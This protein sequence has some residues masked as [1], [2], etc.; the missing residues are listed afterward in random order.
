MADDK[1]KKR[2]ARKALDNP[3]YV[4]RRDE[5]VREKNKKKE[6]RAAKKEQRKRIKEQIKAADAYQ[7]PV[8]E[9]KDSPVEPISPSQ[10]TKVLNIIQKREGGFDEDQYESRE[11]FK[12]KRPSISHIAQ[13]APSGAEVKNKINENAVKKGNTLTEINEAKDN[14]NKVEND[15]N[16]VEKNISDQEAADNVQNQIISN[17]IKDQDDADVKTRQEQAGYVPY[18]GDGSFVGQLAR[19][20]DGGYDLT[21]EDL[22]KMGEEH[23]KQFELQKA[24]APSAAVEKLGMEYYYPP[25]QDY[26]T[27]SFTGRYIGSRQLVAA[28]GALFP[29]GLVDAR[30]RAQQEKA[31]AKAD[32]EANFWKLEGTAEQYDEMYKDIGMDVLL[33]Y[34]NLSAG[35]IEGLLAGK[36]K[37]SQEFL[38][39][40]Y[41]YK[42]RG[43]MI[44]DANTMVDDLI[45]NIGTEG[46]YYPPEIIKTANDFRAGTSNL[47]D[48]FDGKAMGD[49]QVKA[50]INS[51]RSFENF[52]EIA[53]KELALMLKDNANELPLNMNNPDWGKMDAE[54]NSIFAQNMQQAINQVKNKGVGYD[55][56]T[57]AMME[58]YDVQEVERIVRT[59]YENHNLWEGEDLE[60]QIESGVK[61]FMAVLPDKIDIDH[62]LQANKS[63]EAYRARLAAE[64]LELKKYRVAKD[65]Y[66][67]WEGANGDQEAI[68]D[69]LH[70]I[71]NDPK[72]KITSD[73][74]DKEK[75]KIRNAKR[76]AKKNL[77]K[78]ANM[79]PTNLGG[80]IVYKIP[81]EGTHIG[82]APA[83]DMLVISP[84]DG[85]LYRAKSLYNIYSKRKDKQGGKLSKEDQATFNELKEVVV[86]Q[87]GQNIQ[88]H[89]SGR[90][91]GSS[92]YDRSQSA[93]IPN[94]RYEGDYGLDDMKNTGYL[95]GRVGIPIDMKDAKE[96][97]MYKDG[98]KPSKLNYVQMFDSE[99]ENTTRTALLFEGT[100]ENRDS[101][102]SIDFSDPMY[103]VGGE[104]Q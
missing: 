83:D 71:D 51:L 66:N 82:S 86:N 42:A 18:P 32:L 21:D 38:R 58:F 52:H 84:K 23:R 55:E 3:D 25:Q 50:M 98:Y 26:V 56:F 40:M 36:T 62:T 53:N 14:A 95:S 28:T 61:Y 2:K 88:H 8:E 13:N 33:K 20:G 103:Q 24:L 74:S 102:Y 73:M 63:I 64:E 70:K 97:E 60:K 46:T 85:K 72:Y 27:S 92:V 54:G 77:Y 69:E 35:D 45:S 94:G 91:E 30:K 19:D 29:E 80:S 65:Y 87:K 16:N 17:E 100:R 89:I 68:N 79:N 48:Y 6:E 43:K 5:K 22:A 101:K 57:S 78:N 10:K 39:A 96:V 9:G 47:Y 12:A 37:L 59:I 81:T 11:D 49:D 7:R 90:F 34:Y 15:I 1:R 76:M 93:Y 31:Q 44:V 99:N 75:K 67:L 104:D 4:A 41:D